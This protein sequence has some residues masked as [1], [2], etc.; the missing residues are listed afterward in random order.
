MPMIERRGVTLI[1]VSVGNLDNGDVIQLALPFDRTQRELA[2][3]GAR[4]RARPVRIGFGHPG[5]VARPGSGLV[6][7]D[8]PRLKTD[9]FPIPVGQS[10]PTTML[11]MK[12]PAMP[13]RDDAP[14]GAPCWV[15]LFTSDPERTQ[16]FYSELFGWTCEDGR[17]EYGGY[18]NFSKDGVQVAGG[19]RNDGEPARPTTGRSTWRRRTR[20][21]RSTPRP[22]TAAR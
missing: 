19:M 16:A 22:P 13:L 9:E 20:R 21:R 17:A 1:G 14:I 4:R 10:K 8:A 5:G 18:F 2:R 3:R 12:E 6:D 7:P 11:Q 15:D